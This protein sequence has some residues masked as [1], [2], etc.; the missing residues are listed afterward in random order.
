MTAECP[1]CGRPCE[2]AKDR[3]FVDGV[4]FR[5]VPCRTSWARA[6]EP[7]VSVRA[8]VPAIGAIVPS[9]GSIVPAVPPSVPPPIEIPSAPPPPRALLSPR[10][11]LAIDAWLA[12]VVVIG[13]GLGFVASNGSADSSGASRESAS[14]PSRAVTK[15]ANA[16]AVAVAP[17]AESE[18]E[19]NEPAGP[20]VPMKVQNVVLAPGRKIGDDVSGVAPSPA[21]ASASTRHRA[22]AAA[23]SN[24]A[25]SKWNGRRSDPCNCGTD[26]ECTIRCR[27]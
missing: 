6:S 15:S 20:I 26:Y 19:T 24:G 23:A 22:K 2:E 13:V 10:A 18:P 11:R 4:L 5:C 3:P 8:I 21:P 14:A 1:C 12:A 25:E 17:P 7:A 27:P 16:G 9:V